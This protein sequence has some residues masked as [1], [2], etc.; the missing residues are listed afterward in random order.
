MELSTP[1][2]KQPLASLSGY[3]FSSHSSQAGK[4]AASAA[5]GGLPALVT[6]YFTSEEWLQLN[7]GEYHDPEHP[8]LVA[9]TVK[10]LAKGAGRSPER[11][12]FLQQV[13]ILH[14]VDDRV[15]LDGNNNFEFKEG[16]SPARVPFT[17]A[18]MDSNKAE[19][20]KRFDWNTEQFLEAKAL[21]AGTEHPLNDQVGPKQEH[22]LPGYHG[23]SPKTILQ[24]QIQAL[25]PE[26]QSRAL[27][28]IPL[29]RYAD[30]S[31]EY[32]EG[33]PGAK[34]TVQGLADEIKVPY[35]ALIQTTSGFVGGLGQDNP[36]LGDEPSVVLN[37]VSKEL[38]LKTQ[39]GSSQPAKLREFLSP[40]HQKSL[41]E[42]Q[43][44]LADAI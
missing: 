3:L 23:K 32:Q 4:E 44:N 41:A 6:N 10:T 21:I 28:D 13:A 16:A 36:A 24:E 38:G 29:L 22:N 5:A 14:D 31:A 39:Q 9:D 40:E 20:Q 8:V 30:Q 11:V 43:W 2:E 26:N 7:P 18:F 19:L 12:A 33:I 1:G 35:S 27:E 25:K 17:L 42:I 34:E 37:Q 15:T